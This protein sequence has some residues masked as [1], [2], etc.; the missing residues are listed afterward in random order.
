MNKLNIEDLSVVYHGK[1][2]QVRAVDHVSF[3]V[4]AGD[5]LG[6]IGAV[7]YTHL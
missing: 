7:S 6:I 4:D 5:S 3:S 1:E 2:K